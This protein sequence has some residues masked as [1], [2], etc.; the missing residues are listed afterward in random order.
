MSKLPIYLSVLML[1]GVA[2]G[3]GQT[4]PPSPGSS[5]Q[6]APAEK[7]AAPTGT[8]S[9]AQTTIR[10]QLLQ[11]SF[12]EV[13]ASNQHVR[14]TTWAALDRTVTVVLAGF[15]DWSSKAGNDPN[16][17][18]L[19]LGGRMIPDLEPSVIVRSQEYV[20]FELSI[21][22]R[23]VLV[24]ILTAARSA[25]GHT[26]PLSVGLKDTKQPF[27][28]K[29]FLTLGVYPRWAPAVTA[30]LI[31]LVVGLILLGKYTTL[32]KDT[33]LGPDPK[34]PFSLAKT[35]MAWWFALVVGAYLYIWLITGE[36]NPPT[37]SVLALIGI[38]SAT[39]RIALKLE[40]AA[41]NGRIGALTQAAPPPSTELYT[42]L[43]QKSFR[44]N[45]VNAELASLPP[46]RATPVLKKWFL[47]DLISDGNGIS[48]HRF[49]MVV[50]TAVLTVVFIRSVIR[51]L[52]MPDFDAT[53][54]GLMGISSGTYVGFKFP[55]KPK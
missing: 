48:F 23:D 34:A 24:A 37:G 43:Q 26:L 5:T 13:V 29:Q 9:G 21:K 17:L 8:D 46:K 47:M 28:S 15:Q 38:S 18:R 14:T 6:I 3:F 44:A 19:F 53:L 20:N 30:G 31:A 4:P 54:L 25:P 39:G 52:A 27:D 33:S 49:Q 35:Q 10:E 50:W 7:T 45:Q 42:E 12:P 2:L 40:L 51:D 41:L 11:G 55:E 22:P 36:Y 1:L 32:L 16:N